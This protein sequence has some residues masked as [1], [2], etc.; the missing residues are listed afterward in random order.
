MFITCNLRL[1][2]QLFRTQDQE[3]SP[4][5]RVQYCLEVDKL[6]TNFMRANHCI[7]VQLGNKV[8][9]KVWW[10]HAISY[11]EGQVLHK[12]YWIIASIWVVGVGLYW[13]SQE[14]DKE[15]S[16]SIWRNHKAWGN[17]PEIFN[18]LAFTTFVNFS[19]LCPHILCTETDLTMDLALLCF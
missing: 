17:V 10:Y 18:K 2:Y 5:F 7:L 12:I 1:M 9:I 8:I 3:A 4:C 14:C 16:K 15:F 13:M 11:V 19:R 6:L